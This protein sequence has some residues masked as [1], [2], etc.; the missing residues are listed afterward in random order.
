MTREIRKGPLPGCL[1]GQ[2]YKAANGWNASISP[3]PD[4]FETHRTN[5]MSNV[6]LDSNRLEVGALYVAI[7]YRNLDESNTSFFWGL[8]LH[9]PNGSRTGYKFQ[10][11]DTNGK[12]YQLRESEAGSLLYTIALI[13]M[14]RIAGPNLLTRFQLYEIVAAIKDKDTDLSR[15]AYTCQQWIKEIVKVLRDR[16]MLTC[17]IMPRHCLVASLAPSF[18]RHGLTSDT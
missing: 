4:T 16:R 7:S 13:A 18:T 17:N 1:T 3:S 11:I 5:I 12:F 15:G 8:Y 14:V 6:V 2:S 9:A 10:L